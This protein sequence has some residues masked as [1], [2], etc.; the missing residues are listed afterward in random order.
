MKLY[1]GTSG[2][3]YKEWKGAFYPEDL[4]NDAMLGF[5]AGRLPAVE[6]NNT[7][8]R[9]PRTN[10]I[11]SWASQVPE[12]FRFVLKATRRITHFKRLKEP[13]KEL[14]FMLGQFALLGERLG[15]I[16]FQLPP[17]MKQDVPRL[18]AFLELLP[19]GTRAAF[20]FRNETW[21]DD[22]TYEALKKKDYAL[23]ASDTDDEPDPP[24]VE[25]TDW[26]YFRLRR[27]EYE[28]AKLTEWSARIRATGWKEAFVFFKHEDDG[29]GPALAASFAEQFMA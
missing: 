10:V 23:V 17:N 22:A 14:E 24:V 29:A 13:T 19:D 16:L 25:S 6:I 15:P 3:S 8:Y 27:A 12:D 20:E 11:E 21:F 1:T 26:G 5:Y 28:P 9:M 4:K 2:Y 18:E 7:F